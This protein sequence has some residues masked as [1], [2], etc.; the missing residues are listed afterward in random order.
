MNGDISEFDP[1]TAEVP[2]QQTGLLAGSWPDLPEIKKA[3]LQASAACKKIR[4]LTSGSGPAKQTD[5]VRSYSL[6]PRS[7]APVPWPAS[8]A[9]RSLRFYFSRESYRPLQQ[10]N[11]PQYLHPMD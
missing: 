9:N 3:A 2:R 5:F 7:S 10:S 4:S 1:P 6:P 8:A 11:R